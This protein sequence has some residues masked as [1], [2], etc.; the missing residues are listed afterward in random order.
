MDKIKII[1]D[2]ID[3][4]QNLP[5]DYDE[6]KLNAFEKDAKMI[7]G[8][9]FGIDSPHLKNLEEALTY[10]NQSGALSL[11]TDSRNDIGNDWNNLKNDLLDICNTMK[12]ELELFHK[13]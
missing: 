3:Q 12:K 6:R 8:N 11:M 7:I 13:E 5:K 9:I 4:V 10:F 1:Q 2:L